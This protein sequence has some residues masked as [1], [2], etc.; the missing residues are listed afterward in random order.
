VSELR[1]AERLV[2]AGGTHNYKAAA[3]ILHDLREA[4]G[5]DEGDK[6]ARR[7][8]ANLVKKHPTLSHLKSS[9]RKRGLLES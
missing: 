9:M 2:D 8:A 7:H 4:V 3:E 5:G 1:G 6:T